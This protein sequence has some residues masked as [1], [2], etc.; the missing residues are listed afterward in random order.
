MTFQTHNI[1]FQIRIP[2]ENFKVKTARDQDFL[3]RGICYLT[4]SF[5]VPF[6]NFNALFSWVFQKIIGNFHLEIL[7]NS[8]VL[9]HVFTF[10]CIFY[11]LTLGLR[12]VVNVGHLCLVNWI[13]TQVP[14]SD[15]FIVIT[16][17]QLIDIRQINK[18]QHNVTNKPRRFLSDI[19]NV[20]TFLHVFFL[21]LLA[22][23]VFFLAISS[24]HWLVLVGQHFGK[25]TTKKL[26][27]VPSENCTVNSRREKSFLSFNVWQTLLSAGYV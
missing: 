6:Q 5:F 3:I 17:R 8:L 20:L 2:N 22:F 26:I 12:R 21:L 10:S 13:W 24:S 9:L 27:N 14:K 25:I 7:V 18:T 19:M 1:F 16:S 11:L 23:F 15:F 4:N